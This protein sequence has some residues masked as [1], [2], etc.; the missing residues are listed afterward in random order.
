MSF[1]KDPDKL[2][3]LSSSVEADGSLTTLDD[4]FDLT[5]AVPALEDAALTPPSVM[6][7]VT[8][9]EVLFIGVLWSSVIMMGGVVP[10]AINRP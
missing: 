9:A 3:F 10:L 1:L 4:R 7:L 2:G 6:A 5:E 8:E